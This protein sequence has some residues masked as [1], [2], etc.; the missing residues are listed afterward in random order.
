MILSLKP[1]EEMNV[2]ERL[3]HWVRRRDGHCLCLLE[4]P[5]RVYWSVVNESKRQI[6]FTIDTNSGQP[7]ELEPFKP[8][9]DTS[10][11]VHCGHDIRWEKIAIPPRWEH[12]R[13]MSGD[14]ASRLHWICECGCMTPEP[15]EV[16][17]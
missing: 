10:L 14:E 12:V 9:P 1:Y 16:P 15:K 11:C 3:I 13:V 5:N 2:D 8:E 17:L 6:L 7:I 4:S